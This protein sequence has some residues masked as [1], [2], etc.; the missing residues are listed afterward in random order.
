M[1]TETDL[2]TYRLIVCNYFSTVNL[3]IKMLKIRKITT[4]P[5]QV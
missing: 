4:L 2:L 1:I 5:F 3:K